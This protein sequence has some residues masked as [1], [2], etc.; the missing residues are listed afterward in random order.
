MEGLSRRH[1]YRLFGR[2]S[3]GVDEGGLTRRA[4]RIAGAIALGLIAAILAFAVTGA[5][6]AIAEALTVLLE[7]FGF[8]ALAADTMDLGW[9]TLHLLHVQIGVPSFASHVETRRWKLM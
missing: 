1:I 4:L 9:N 6:D 5:L 3:H 8:L 7:T 2:W